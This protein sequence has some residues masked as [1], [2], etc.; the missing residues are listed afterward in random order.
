MSLQACIPVLSMRLSNCGFAEVLRA[1]Y[2]NPGESSTAM[3]IRQRRPLMD[4]WRQNA[5]GVIALRNREA[6]QAL[7][8]GLQNMTATPS[9]SM[10]ASTPAV[11]LTPMFTSPLQPHAIMA[12]ANGGQTPIVSPL[13]S[14]IATSPLQEDGRIFVNSHS[15]GRREVYE[16]S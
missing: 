3:I 11:A 4:R 2:D 16:I 15:G 7:E 13:G 6:R 8:S 5:Q 12:F 9:P 1:S 10:Q 14:G